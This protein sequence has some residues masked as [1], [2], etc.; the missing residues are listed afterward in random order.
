MKKLILFILFF[1]I[2]PAFSQASLDSLLRTWM[3]ESYPDTLRVDAGWKYIWDGVLFSRPDSAYI[4]A[5]QLVQ[6]AIET[7][8][9]SRISQAKA[10][11]G[12]SFAI[13]GM[14]PDAL[15]HFNDALEYS[16]SAGDQNQIAMT[17]TNVARVHSAMGQ[18]EE[19]LKSMR[20]AQS[21]FETNGDDHTLASTLSDIGL[22]L[23]QLGDYETSIQE[24][25]KAYEIFDRLGD[26]RG[27]SHALSNIGTANSYMGNH[28]AA[29]K[30]FR[31]SLEF[32]I[33]SNDRI[34]LGNIYNNIAMVYT[35]QGNEESA[36]KYL[37]TALENSRELGS[38]DGASLTLAN[39]GTIYGGMGKYG[40][41]L[42]YF[43]ESLKIVEPTGDE[44]KISTA[45]DG[46]GKAK[47]AL[48]DSAYFAGN[49]IIAEEFWNESIEVLNR[50]LDIR[51]KI[52]SA[53]GMA[54]CYNNIGLCERSRGNYQLAI[55]NHRKA[56]EISSQ[57]G[58]QLERI[59]SSRYLIENQMALNDFTQIETAVDNLLS[60]RNRDL[61]LNF[62]ILT[63][64]EKEKFYALMKPE[65]D[66][67][68]DYAL[69]RQSAQP[70][71][72][73]QVFDN[74]LKTKGL[75]LKSSTALRNAILD[76]DDSTLIEN[77]TRWLAIKRRIARNF[78]EG[79]S[80]DDL[81]QKAIDL[82][83]ELVAMSQD[84]SASQRVQ[85]VTWLDVKSKLSAQEAAVEFVCFDHSSD[86]T[87]GT[88]VEVLYCALVIKPDSR[89]PEFI[90][91]FSESS[92]KKIIGTFPGNNLSYIDQV[93]GSGD[94]IKTQL[95][96]LI[97]KPIE[98]SLIGIKKVYVSPVGLLHKISFSALASSQDVFL[99]D[100][101]EIET[102]ASSGGIAI[103]HAST[104]AKT[105]ESEVTLFGGIEY[106]SDSSSTR[107]WNYLDGSLAETDQIEQ[108]LKKNNQKVN[109]FN[110]ASATEE[111]F[112]RIASDSYILHIATHGFF[113]PD[114]E[115]LV[116]EIADET[117]DQELIFRGGTSGA[118][119]YQYGLFSFVRNKSPLMRS[120]LV[121]AGANDVWDKTAVTDQEMD[122]REDGVLTAQEVALIDMRQT[123]LVV[124]SACETGLGDIKGSEGVYGL[125]RAFKMAGVKYIIMSLWQVPDKET[126]EF[127]TTFYK[128]LTKMNDIR[129]AFNA[130]QRVMRK[131]YDPYYW[132]AFVLIE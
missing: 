45:L 43:V 10:V 120:G 114:P 129:E 124:L 90:Q 6:L 61:R 85:E 40:Q 47:T 8:D 58:A 52:S 97:W 103:T 20:A 111:Q 89:Y 115:K 130:T 63:E 2:S 50:S 65:Y 56:L 131:K 55:Q 59:T 51:T 126:A 57:C 41:A 38:L 28:S 23:Y 36:L 68:Y 7:G 29:L 84:F 11:V 12:V 96:D 67:F 42:E 119:S 132:G 17:N 13:R 104:S 16:K 78:S 64:D 72:S 35:A 81:E 48:G 108:I 83:K 33:K 21:V 121:F 94:N 109:Y 3:N 69:R 15:V 44:F 123:E 79:I 74:V 102:R 80:T 60:C 116:A 75:L 49:K 39:I 122:L 113:Y 76:S 106:D 127:M 62:S 98:R 24:S 77:Y 19:A 71:L 27:A 93:Y 125:Q 34:S 18:Y 54:E 37:I 5:A 73:K 88:P 70:E 101:Y 87:F 4:L 117:E 22:M 32:Q 118:N 92:L 128:N 66:L 99:C 112:K 1:S 53:H 91:L 30:Y 9:A 105:A 100:S 110:L 95:Y 107:V 14:F 82:E 26:L 31:T 86:H 46:I 25:T